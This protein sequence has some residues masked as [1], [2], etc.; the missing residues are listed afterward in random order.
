MSSKKKRKGMVFHHEGADTPAATPAAEH[1]PACFVVPKPGKASEGGMEQSTCVTNEEADMVGKPNMCPSKE[2]IRTSGGL[3][4]LKHPTSSNPH[5][6]NLS[7]DSS[8]KG[9]RV[10]LDNNS[11][12]NEFFRCK[13]EMILTKQGSRMFPYCRFRISGLQPSRKYSLIMDI[14]PLDNSHYKWT[15]KNWQVAG[16]AECHV[17]RQPFAHPESPSTGQHWM[18]N[19]VSFY[20][21]KLTNNISDQEGNTI[22]HPMHRYLPRL[23]VVQ[24]DKAAKD[25]KLNGPSVVTFTF[26]QTEFIAVTAYQNSQF[27]Q[28]KVDYNPFAKGLKEDVSTS[29]GMKLKLNSGKDSHKD[30][31][32]MT[33]EQHPVKKSL[34]S[35][36]ANHKPRSSKA[37]DSKPSVSNDLQKNSTTNKDQSPAKVPDE[38]LCSSSRPAQKL[39]SE[40]IREAHVSLHRCNL[41][42]LGIDNSTSH[43]TELTNTKTTALKNSRDVCKKDNVSGKTHSETSPEKKS[44]TPLTKR[45]IKGDKGV[46]NSLDFKDNVRTDCSEVSKVVAVPVVSQNFSVDSDHQPKSEAPSEMS[47]KQH[48]RPAPLPL[49]ALALFLKQHSTKSKK[50]KS[51]PDS[52][53]PA[54][55]SEPLSGSQSSAAASACLPSDH[56]SNAAGSSKYLTDDFTKPDN[57]ASGHTVVEVHPGKMGL[58]VTGQAVETALQ[59]SGPSCPGA[60]LTPEPKGPRNDECMVP[61]SVA[62][63]PGSDLAVPDGTLVLPNSDQPFCSFG[64]STSTISSTLATSSSSPILS[65]ALDTVLPALNSPQTPTITESST[66]PS[67]PPTTNSLLPDPEC[68]S[69]GFEPLSPTCSPEPLPP[70][71]TSLT[72]QLDCSTSALTPK[73]VPP[74]E[75]PPSE[76]SA[77]SV[78]KW[79]TVLPPPEP[80]IDDSFTTF[81]TT[82]QTLPLVSIALPLLPSPTPSH[83]EPQ[84]LD[85]SVST[86][87]RGPTPS[88]QENEQSLPFPAELS[89]LVLQLPLSPTFSSLD[90]DGLS[91][92]PSIADLV[93]FFST[94]DDLAMGVEFS[95]TEAVAVTCSPPTT[96]EANAQEPSQQVQPV[97]ANKPCKRKKKSRRRKLAQMNKDQKVDESTYTSM[98]PNLEEVEEQ[99]F[100]SFTS[101]EALKLH[102][103]DSSEETVT[104]PQTTPEGHVTQH[105]TTTPE[106]HVTQPQTTT[107]EG[108]VT[109]PQT[110]TPEGHVTRPQTPS[111]G[112]LTQTQTPPE[113]HLIP[114]T[115]P[116][117]YL[118]QPQTTPE[119]AESQE[120]RI[121]VCEKTLL[122]DLKL[123]KHKQVIHPVLQE[124]GLKMNLLDSTLA[125]DLQYLG[126]RLPIPPPGVSLEP[127]TQELPPPQGASAAF[128]SRTGKTT[129]VTQIKGWREKFSPSE[130]PPTPSSARPEAGPSSDL[131]KKNLSAF[132]SD[133]LDEYLENEGKLIDERAASF[134]QPLVEPVVYEL[135]TRSTSYVRTLDSVLKKHGVSSPT[136]DLISGFVPPSKRPKLS[137]KEMK[138][139]RKGERKQRGPKQTRLRPEPAAGP[140]STPEPGPAEP[141]LVPKLPAVPTPAVSPPSKL[142][143]DSHKSKRNQL[144]VQLDH[145]EP[146]TLSP[147]TP[148]FKR[149]RKLKPKTSSQTLSPPRSTQ[150]PQD[151]SEDLAPLESDSELGTGADPGDEAHKDSGPV[152][153]RALLR[154]KDLE[155]GVV[156][157]GRPRTSITEERAAIALTSLFTLMGFVSENPTAPLQLIRR[158][159]PPC[160]NEFCRLGC[161]CSS[162]SHVS[163]ISHCGR[164][165][166]MFGCSCLKQKV[167]LLKNLD[168]SDS[169]PSQHGTTRKRRRRRRMKMAYVL[170]E[171]DSVS[172]PAERVQILWK[173]DGRDSDPDPI[174]VPEAATPPPATESR[175]SNSSCARV[176][177]YRGKRRS[178]KQKEETKDVKSKSV[179]LKSLRQKDRTLKT[180]TRPSSPPPAG[181]PAQPAPSSPPPEPTP[182]PSKRLIILAECKW[183][184]DAD[185]NYVLKK[186]CEAMAQDRLDGPFWIRKYLISPISQTVEQS[187]ADH[188]I[189][190]KIHIS[191]PRVERESPAAPPTAGPGTQSKKPQQPQVTCEAE[192]LQYHQQEVMEEAEPLDDCQQK[193]ME[194][195]EPLEDWQRQV[196]ED[197]IPEE[198][199]STPLQVDNRRGRGR[200]G[201]RKRTKA[202]KKRRERKR[203]KKKKMV[204]MALPFLTGISPAGFL[205]AN[206]KQPGGTDHL[207]QVNGKLYPLAK[208]QLGKMGALHPANRLA[209]YLTGRVGSN[210]KPQ[211]PSSSSSSSSQPPHTQSSGPTPQTAL[212]TSNLTASATAKP[213]RPVT[214]VTLPTP[215]KDSQVSRSVVQPVNPPLG[216]AAP[217]GSRLLIQV[218]A[219]PPSSGQ[220]MV[221]QLV[222]TASGV[223]YYRRP[224]GKL[225]QLIPI[226]QMRP[227]NPKPPVTGPSGTISSSSSSSPL[228]GLKSF[229]VPPL[230]APLCP[231]SGFLSQKGTCTFKIIPSGSNK[232]P[233]I[234]TCPKLPSQPP[235]KVA[236][237]AGSFTVLQ[238]RFHPP[239]TPVNLISLKP[240]A[241][242]GAELG[243]KT[244]AVSAAPVGPGGMLVP[245][246]PASPQTAPP[247]QSPTET[248]RTPPPPPPSPGSEVRP[249]P[250]S[251]PPAEPEPACDLVDLDII[252]V[253]DYDDAGLVTTE[254]RSTEVV[255]LVGSSS[256]ET[257][258]SSDFEDELSSEEEKTG[259]G[260]RKKHVRRHIHNVLEK[261]RRGRMLHLFEGLRREV[262][263]NYDKTSKISTLNKAVQLIQELKTTESDLQKKK[264]RLMK[265]REE[266]LSTL[267]PTTD[268]SRESGTGTLTRPGL[269]VVDLSDQTDELTE[270]SSDEDRADRADSVEG[271]ARSVTMETE[272][273]NSQLDVA[274]WMMKNPEAQ[275]VTAAFR[276]LR[277]AMNSNSSSKSFLLQQARHQIQTLQTEMQ[278]LRSVKILLNQQRN[279]YI[280]RISQRSGK[281][282]QT[283]LRKLQYLSSKQKMMEEQE[284]H[285]AANAGGGASDPP[286]G[287]ASDDDIII[288]STYSQQ[289]T[290]Q[291][292]PTLVSAPPTITPVQMSQRTLQVSKPILAPPAV[293]QN[294]PVVRDRPRTIPNILSRSKNPAPSFLLKKT[295]EGEAPSIQSLVPTLSLVGAALPGQPVLTLSPLMSGPT[296][297]QTGSTPG[298][299]SVTL[300][301]PSLANQQI[302]LTSQPHPTTGKIY[303]S[304]VPLTA[305]NLTASNLNNLLHLVQPAT[306]QQQQQQLVPAGEPAPPPPLVVS[307]GPDLSSDQIKDQDQDQDQAPSQTDTRPES[308]SSLS[309]PSTPAP[310]SSLCPGLSADHRVGLSVGGPLGPGSRGDGETESLTSLLNEIVFLNQQTVSTATTAGVLS[311]T[312]ATVGGAN[313]QGHARSPWALQPDPDSD[314]TVTMETEEPGLQGHAETMHVG[315]QTGQAN[316]NTKGGVLAPPP[317]LQMKVGGVKVAEPAS[318]DR[319]AAAGR[320]VGGVRMEE[321]VAWRPMPRLVPLGLRGN[322]PS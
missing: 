256:G 230:P 234:V 285:Q 93:H 190:Y 139:S 165:P 253:D 37:A 141:N 98:Q 238:P 169:S 131:P 310:S 177:G 232:E 215:A 282:E 201:W 277:S 49:P 182:K 210:R 209:A 58:N 299:A 283:V 8:C 266:Y 54:L 263:L 202:E 136:S 74:E 16:K 274:E 113:G 289:Q 221:L 40:L 100:I 46:L 130:A 254:T 196:E 178:Q 44:E 270:N 83:A 211:G 204:S 65:P 179:R 305:T 257:E 158:R 280:R 302:H 105:Q 151:I 199:G 135:P 187:G 1:P 203:M 81:Q 214:L 311:E 71:P 219:A 275:N 298:V 43:R 9:I 95:N 53:P 236:K 157:E 154:Q 160:L 181:E 231:G 144:K 312:D 321:G 42:E 63:S 115:P 102:I 125:I 162:L 212:S 62:E 161:V 295:V 303:S 35:L 68:C 36:L 308:S 322:P 260:E 278:R 249:V 261:R 55:P 192:P 27:A 168:G 146:L 119:N 52:P 143:T 172:Q 224:D 294:A 247:S 97:P 6:E 120:Q 207:V 163:R 114:Q 153:T 218:P 228:S 70:L 147:Q 134:S 197:D 47:V 116:E 208:I 41:E 86:P 138:A 89:P 10:T 4:A 200:G 111:E 72:L 156:W 12:W 173:R 265:R 170:K 88:L 87:P 75:L 176:R 291:A 59:P 61:I 220:R 124:V 315:P 39:F 301:I 79:H 112:H 7:P 57:Q 103:A 28:L 244:V 110:T 31:G 255:D 320:S 85:M 30:G 258:N 213:P 84:T 18:Q 186:L 142:I 246:K 15:G 288:M 184:S 108:H 3:P 313:E 250:P 188:C 152:M 166:C 241:G 50:A 133:M 175:E 279:S 243:V 109:Q 121:S 242:Q 48:K 226:S 319:A 104:Q 106:G 195:A 185:R 73:A 148:T 2:A 132:C 286:T 96:V 233:I 17:K 222:Q 306:K 150:P 118:I 206:R 164:P 23:H 251:H 13:T 127:L 137:L 316:E 159:A 145:T 300:N 67:D 293:S 297:L 14:Q 252:C 69:F 34:K 193:V 5:S 64:T 117:G 38:S 271:E 129:D 180:K 194:E 24:T 66:L 292:P 281:S 287:D 227:F 205:S 217:E 11:M 290:P 92:T 123:M 94:D 183:V 78:F 45:K 99:L 245:Q 122:R 101:K 171:A 21:L 149:R 225:I 90:G 268:K 309:P 189:Q 51:K 269:V 76:H 77:T 80:Y 272:E 284:R 267:V 276:A 235:S 239:A 26:P 32:T 259:G 33:N 19:P 126:V 317:L 155:D 273:E 91:P 56:A 240:S 264:R 29:W 314:Y 191:R 262:G 304:S 237:A 22:L 229:S 174:H 140:V 128:V 20:K 307:A 107:P 296:V 82:S 167:V 198:E 248:H 216:M 60:V 223:Q 25:I 318:S